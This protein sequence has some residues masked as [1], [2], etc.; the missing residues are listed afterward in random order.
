M[1]F[2]WEQFIE[3]LVLISLISAG[4]ILPIILILAYSHFGL[5]PGAAAGAGL[6][7]YVLLLTA[8]A[9]VGRK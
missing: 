6:G 2:D 7:T 8:A 1:T 9:C 5:S 3:S 4:F